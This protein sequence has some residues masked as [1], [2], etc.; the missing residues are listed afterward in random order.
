MDL[1]STP[2]TIVLIEEDGTV[3]SVSPEFE[4]LSGYRKEEVEG[5]LRWT[6]LLAVEDVE[7]VKGF[8]RQR[9]S[10]PSKAPRACPAGL[11]IKDN[12]VRRVLI[13]IEKIPGTTRSALSILDVT[14]WK[15]T[16]ERLTFM[17]T[18]DV[19]TGLPNRTLF[20]DRLTVTLAH[21]RRTQRKFVV[22]L[23]DLDKFKEINDSM[24]HDFGDEIL[25]VVA[26]RLQKVIRK[27]D[28]LARMGGD[29]FLFLFPDMGQI[30]HATLVAEKLLDA[31]REPFSVQHRRFSLSASIGISIF[32]D[33]G[34]D[35]E[36]LMR[37][38]DIAMYQAKGMG[39]NQASYYRAET[40]SIQ[41][42]I[43]LIEQDTSLAD[44]VRAMLAF[45]EAPKFSVEWISRLSMVPEQL[46]AAHIDLIITD[47]FLPDSVGLETLAKILNQTPDIPVIV[48]VN[49]DDVLLGREAVAAGAQ[50]FLVKDQIDDA[51]LERS[52]RYAMERHEL[53]LELKQQR[54]IATVSMKTLLN[55]A[56]QSVVILD[57]DFTILFVNR[58][59]EVLLGKTAKELLGTTLG[60]VIISGEDSAPEIE[61]N[62]NLRERLEGSVTG[63]VWRNE[64]AYMVCLRDVRATSE[65]ERE[66]RPFDQ[67]RRV[68]EEIIHLLAST[69]GERD[70]YL[71]DHQRRVTTLAC[72]IAREMGFPPERIEGLEVAAMIHDVG[73]IYLPPEILNKPG[74]LNDREFSLVKMHPQIGYD[75]LKDLQSPWPVADIILQHHERLD[76]SGYPRGLSRDEILPEARILAVAD[77][78][79]SLLSPRSYRPARSVDETLAEV[80]NHDSALYD[81]DVVKVCRD[82]FH[83]KEFAF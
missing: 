74:P 9:M 47:L 67:W 51:L 41:S 70:I 77:A 34:G 36:T 75:M 35:I 69:I 42:R 63:T 22:M 66:K 20:N 53:Q 10:D 37:T 71:S 40:E 16:E 80:S 38:A 25:R 26:L 14:E 48:L 12:G 78:V 33:H 6:D 57:Q 13:S 49:S 59:A 24:G 43:L 61:L 28:T 58:S 56:P 64:R 18:R 23:L 5:N 11:H 44:N 8:Y 82:L 81:S 79:E 55:D 73:K 72:A 45:G 21:A 50:D 27:S 83:D 76:G 31:F 15:L 2:L 54:E 32:P 7:R 60:D 19:L 68:M 1:E 46:A 62:L 3:V 4:G 39:G 29:E 30:D 17:A 52:I 65:P